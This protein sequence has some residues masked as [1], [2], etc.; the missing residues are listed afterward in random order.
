M[1]GGGEEGRRNESL[2]FWFLFYES[3]LCLYFAFP[4]CTTVVAITL[5]T[6]V[7][8]PE[9]SESGGRATQN[10]NSLDVCQSESVE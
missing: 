5:N 9:S 1:R 2:K 4:C 3:S 7:D 6:I 8:Q 10:E